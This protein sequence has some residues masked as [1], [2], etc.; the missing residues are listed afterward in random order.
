MLTAY[1]ANAEI[2]LLMKWKLTSRKVK[3]SRLSQGFQ[4]FPIVVFNVGVKIRSR[5][6]SVSII[7]YVKL[8]WIDE[9][10]IITE[11]LSDITSSIQWKVELQ[12]WANFLCLKGVCLR[13][14]WKHIGAQCVPIG[15]RNQVFDYPSLLISF[16]IVL[17]MICFEF[18][19]DQIF[20][21]VFAFLYPLYF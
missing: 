4:S 21:K 1:A 16:G 5:L 18:N 13:S 7:L 14:V 17:L 2:L 3:S 9:V 8:I 15:I 12:V 11:F 6:L 20:R 19:N 10:Q